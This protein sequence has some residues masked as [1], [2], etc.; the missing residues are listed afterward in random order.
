M[1]PVPE[2]QHLDGHPEIARGLPYISACLHEPSRSG[3]TQNVRRDIVAEPALVTT[4][5]K[6][7]STL[8]TGF[9]FHSTANRC[10]HRFQRR[11]CASS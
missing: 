10:P 2:R 9:P 8:C 11:R 3:V 6:A 4:L 1:M 5:A 7:L